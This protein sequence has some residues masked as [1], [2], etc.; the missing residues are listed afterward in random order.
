MRKGSLNEK[1]NLFSF[2]MQ[3]AALREEGSTRNEGNQG[4]TI[5]TLVTHRHAVKLS[6]DSE[7]APRRGVGSCLRR[8]AGGGATVWSANL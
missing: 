5:M 6:R 8:R 4:K 2:Q 1:D 7:R 3:L